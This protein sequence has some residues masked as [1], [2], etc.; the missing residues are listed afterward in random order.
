MKPV[1]INLARP[2]WQRSLLNTGA[3]WWLGAL[4]GAVLLVA[5]G[6][7]MRQLLDEQAQREARIRASLRTPQVSATPAALIPAPQATAVNSAVHQLNLPWRELAASLDGANTQGVSLLALEPDARARKLKLQA[8][9]AGS[10]AMVAYIEALKHQ[11]LI[12]SVLLTRHEI[13][14]GDA[15]R[16]IRFQLELQWSTRGGQP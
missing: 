4:A 12:L 1:R 3:G 15:A 16:P 14:E 10:D 6:I 11:P 9:A 8:E 7:G 13:N 2:G 5:A